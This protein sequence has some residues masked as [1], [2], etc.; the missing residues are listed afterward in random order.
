MKNEMEN[1]YAWQQRLIRR[2]GGYTKDDFES[3]QREI[4][5]LHKAL[6]DALES[7]EDADVQLAERT[8]R[9]G[10]GEKI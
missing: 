9:R 10:L 1:T 2:Y 8:I 5:K 6:A 7:M 4:A 3:Q